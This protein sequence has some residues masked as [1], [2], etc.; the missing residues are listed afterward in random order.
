M[1]MSEETKLRLMVIPIVA[2][3]AVTMIV[4]GWQQ[5]GEQV[6]IDVEEGYEEIGI[7]YLP[8]L[9]MGKTFRNETTGNYYKNATAITY[10]EEK[11]NSLHFQVIVESIVR[12]SDEHEIDLKL[13]AD[14]NF[15]EKFE[16]EKLLFQMQELNAK[17]VSRNHH[18]FD[19]TFVKENNVDLWPQEKYIGGSLGT[20][21]AYIGF[22]INGNRFSA[23]G[24]VTWTIPRSNWN[25]TYTLR[26]QSFVKG[27]AQDVPATVEVYIQERG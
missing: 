1:S 20:H 23:E 9:D 16:P 15:K 10:L 6:E 19:I 5:E 12:S 17:N 18:D 11:N 8:R 3:L 21:P 26:L 13:Q 2:M 14:G 25:N 27:L 7:E 24:H 4:A 22:D